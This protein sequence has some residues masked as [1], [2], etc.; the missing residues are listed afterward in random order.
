MYSSSRLGLVIAS[1]TV[2]VVMT[3][4]C[5]SSP[6]VSATLADA[7]FATSGGN[8]FNCTTPSRPATARSVSTDGMECS[9]KR[10]ADGS[11]TTT[12]VTEIF[13]IGCGDGHGAFLTLTCAGDGKTRVVSGTATLSLLGSCD[14]PKQ[15]PTSGQTFTFTD[16]APGDTQSQPLSDCAAFSNFCTV[17]DP[18]AFNELKASVS[19]TNPSQP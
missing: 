3:A 12:P 9:P 16:L 2:A 14:T 13:K 11:F 17:S 1:G 8:L 4:A 6:A 5:G 18:C 15:P 7:S 10:A 19:I